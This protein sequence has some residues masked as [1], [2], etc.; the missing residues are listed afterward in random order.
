MVVT[1]ERGGQLMRR[2]TFLR[3]GVA[4]AVVGGLAGCASDTDSEPSDSASTTQGPATTTGGQ[5]ET[6]EAAETTT[7]EGDDDEPEIDRPD[8]YRWDMIPGRNDELRNRLSQYVEDQVGG[9]V[10]DHPAFEYSTESERDDHTV[11]FEALKMYRDSNFDIIAQNQSMVPMNQIVDAFVED[12]LY[13]EAK[14]EGFWYNDVNSPQTYDAEGWLN[15]DTVEESLDYGHGLIV[16]IAWNEEG[17]D[18]STPQRAATLRE[19]Y[20]QHHDFDVLAWEAPMETGSLLTGMM[21]S[22][23]DDTIRT[24]NMGDKSWETE[25]S[26]QL[27]APIEEWEVTQE[28]A[29]QHHPVL[30]HTDEWD[31]QG[32][33]FEE[34][35]DEALTMVFGVGT[36]NYL[37]YNRD[38]STSGIVN[39]ITITTGAT[40]QLTRT[41][42]DYN[43][44]DDDVAD[45][46]DIWNLASVAVG[47]Y[48]EDPSING[49]IDTVDPEDDDYDEYFGGGFAF[50]EVE[51]ESVVRDVKRDQ[52]GEYD[53]F[54]ET[55]DELEPV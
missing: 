28:D 26:L 15:A 23:D 14:G 16:S 12:G 5:T 11:D 47:K 31:R 38:E 34:A 49:V 8:N 42:L 46:E 22:P 7:A 17:Q 48:I 25:T 41:M 19:A 43:T 1:G 53:N 44:L 35:K 32:I 39:N 6:T 54:G 29:G 45:F 20:K 21:Y 10:Q 33:S 27:H 36:D 9:V 4:A 18:F 24:L 13:E 3:T 37:D 2:R 30:F 50:Y 51:D 55:F 52:A 40:E